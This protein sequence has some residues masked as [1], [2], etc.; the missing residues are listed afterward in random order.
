VKVRGDGGS[1]QG[2][3]ALTKGVNGEGRRS[4]WEKREGREGVAHLA[5]LTLRPIK[6][7]SYSK[8]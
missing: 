1:C 3:L 7:K 8:E 5:N 4:C 6:M 2:A